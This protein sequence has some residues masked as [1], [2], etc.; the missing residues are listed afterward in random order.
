MCYHG[1]AHV[2]HD[3]MIHGGQMVEHYRAIHLVP[4][5]DLSDQCTCALHEYGMPWWSTQMVDQPTATVL[6]HRWNTG[7]LCYL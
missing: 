5:V 3:R 1:L 2:Q 6:M 4:P 7:T